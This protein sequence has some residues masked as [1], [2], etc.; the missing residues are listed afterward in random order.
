LASGQ[1]EQLTN[2]KFRLESRPS[3]FPLE[4]VF[5]PFPV[6]GRRPRRQ[7]GV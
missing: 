2:A 4:Q 7:V 1:R 6:I 3:A 5:I